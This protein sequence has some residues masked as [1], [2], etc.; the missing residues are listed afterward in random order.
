MRTPSRQASS[1]KLETVIDCD[2]ATDGIPL[3]RVDRMC[4]TIEGPRARNVQIL[5]KAVS[6]GVNFVLLF[7]ALLGMK[8]ESKVGNSVLRIG[9]QYQEMNQNDWYSVRTLDYLFAS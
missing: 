7:V 9:I 5:S 2:I 1:V 8:T 3:L 6:C 4:V